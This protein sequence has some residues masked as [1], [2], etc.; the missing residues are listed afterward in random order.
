MID[1]LRKELRKNHFARLE[2]SVKLCYFAALGERHPQNLPRHNMTPLD[3]QAGCCYLI[4]E[5]TVTGLAAGY[6]DQVRRVY[7]VERRDLW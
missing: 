1:S 4:T 5:G 6:S 2:L 7:S 3:N